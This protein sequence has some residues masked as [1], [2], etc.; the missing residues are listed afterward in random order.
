M[1]CLLLIR[2]GQSF[3][4]SYNVPQSRYTPA[5]HL[6]NTRSTYTDA[7]TDSSA[8]A[9]HNNNLSRL[10]CKNSCNNVNTCRTQWIQSPAAKWGWWC[11]EGCRCNCVG[12]VAAVVCD[13]ELDCITVYCK[14]LPLLCTLPLPFH[15]GKGDVYFN[16][17]CSIWAQ[18]KKGAY[19]QKKWINLPAW[20][21][22][23]FPKTAPAFAAA[24]GP[25]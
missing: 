20:I 22:S 11:S 6:S 5:V 4:I 15:C 10:V 3:S 16:G 24:A 12:I 1:D 9:N 8:A 23:R 13:V 17:S 25:L 19:Q 21:T 7:H 18:R 14:M 2:A